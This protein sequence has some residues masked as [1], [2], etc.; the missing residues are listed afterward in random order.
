MIRTQRCQQTTTLQQLLA[1]HA[2][3]WHTPQVWLTAGLLPL[4]LQAKAALYRYLQHVDSHPGCRSRPASVAEG[5][6]AA[7]AAVSSSHMRAVNHLQ[8]ADAEDP[9]L[10][11]GSAG[12]TC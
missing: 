5:D 6:R 9:W 8:G 2:Q 7:A 4:L 3:P 12:A 1:W 11:V 10:Q